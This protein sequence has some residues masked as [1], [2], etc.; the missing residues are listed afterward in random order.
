M[1]ACTIRDCPRYCQAV[2]AAEILDSFT[3]LTQKQKPGECFLQGTTHWLVREVVSFLARK[4]LSSFLPFLSR[5]LACSLIHPMEAR[6]KSAERLGKVFDQPVSKFHRSSAMGTVTTPSISNRE[7]SI[8]LRNA[9]SK[10]KFE[11]AT[12]T[13]SRVSQS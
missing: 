2:T 8:L 10:A 7:S 12:V 3:H 4:Y 11:F 6:R 1:C 9:V 5:M 13:G